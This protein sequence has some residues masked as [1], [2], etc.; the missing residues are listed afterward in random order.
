MKRPRQPSLT[1]AA[2][3]SDS[4]SAN[5]DAGTLTVDF[6]AGGTANDRLAIRNQGTGT[7]EIGVSGTD[8]TYRR[9][10]HRYLHRRHRWLDAAGRH[11]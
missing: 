5:F 4:D 9:D 2:T 3:V 8:V 11:V 6:T 1:P 10:N 7:G